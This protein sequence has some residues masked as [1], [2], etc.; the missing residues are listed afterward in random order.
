MYKWFEIN[1]VG[2]VK[3][4]VYIEKEKVFKFKFKR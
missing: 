4:M 3:R 1:G 2:W